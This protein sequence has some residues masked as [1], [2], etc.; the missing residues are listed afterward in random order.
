MNIS[1]YKGSTDTI[2]VEVDYKK[3]LAG[4]KDGRWQKDIQNLL[5]LR[6][7]S[8]E[9]SYAESKKSL[10]SFTIAG[11]FHKRAMDQ[12]KEWTTLIVLDIDNLEKQQMYTLFAAFR[13]DP[14]VHA[15]FISPSGAGLKIIIKLL[16]FVGPENHLRAFLALE[17]YFKQ[18]YAVALDKS[19]KDISRLCYVSYDPELYFNE[20][21][22]EFVFEPEKINVGPTTARF[23]ERPDRF[24]GYVI[25]KDAKYAF[26]VCEKW[27]QR[28]HQYET[29]NRNNYIHVLSSNLNRAGVDINDAM[30][31]IYNNYSDLPFKEIETTVHSAYRRQSEHNS[32]DIYNTDVAEADPQE[33]GMTMEEETIYKDTLSLLNAG[34]NKNLIAKLIK[35][36]GIAFFGMDEKYV[37]DIMN[38]AVK[39]NK[40]DINA[41]SLDSTSADEA[42]MRAIDSYKDTGGI[43]TLVPEIDNAM[44]GGLM[45]GS[46]YGFIG[47]GGSFKSLLVQC[48]GSDNSKKDTITLYLN[49]EMSE[50]QLLDRMVNRELKIELLNGLRNETITREQIPEIAQ[51]LKDV[52]KG[53][54]EI[55]SSTGWTHAGIV[56]TV[57]AVEQR[58]KKKVSLIIAD[59]LTQMEDTKKD[60]IRSA[61]FNSGEL[62]TVAKDTDAAVIAL[63]HVSGNIAKHIRDTSKFVRGG[64]KVINNMDAMFCTSLCIDEHASDLDNGDIMYIKNK[65]YLRFIDKRGSG[66]IISKI[67]QVNRPMELLPLDIEPSIMEIKIGRE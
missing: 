23:D 36:F 52:L 42:L 22:Q 5:S 67:V 21:S 39:R 60:E 56:K 10:P 34:I 66:E 15:C 58:T 1:F 27:T 17:E 31:M 4:I 49:G 54:F 61:I 37:G 29:G 19:G 62:K 30:L 44:N 38:K 45:P 47:K 8:G 26:G 7:S 11:T 16:R 57:K 14:F 18:N 12:L 2:G 35:N 51:Q 32:V 65:F 13:E 43:S 55:V 50:L 64:D 41:D 59:G 40:E 63:V 24:K 33:E 25:S 3:I 9:D 48:I 53:N 46:F 6:E 20:E 28:H